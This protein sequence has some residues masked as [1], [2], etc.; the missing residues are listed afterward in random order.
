MKFIDIY[1]EFLDE[2]LFYECFEY[3]NTYFNENHKNKFK[4][5]ISFWDKDIVKDSK[6][7]FV[8]ELD[9]TDKLYEKINEHIKTKLCITNISS[10]SFYWYMPGS[11]I[12]F[13][14]DHNY[15]GGITIYLNKTWDRDTGGLFLFDD[16][17]TNETKAIA[18]KKNLLIHQCGGI[19]HA[20]CPTSK[21]S[22]V[23]K[24]IQI[25]Y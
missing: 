18:P 19:E 8:K 7:V 13:H 16:D 1:N 24:T 10:I 11:H 23:R 15:S 5:N 20:V 25:F 17:K 4:S 22:K 12:P 14:D 9:K 3:S 2:E 6:H 21:N